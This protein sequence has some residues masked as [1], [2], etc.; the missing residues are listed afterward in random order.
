MNDTNK[1]RIYLIYNEHQNFSEFIK[2]S[3]LYKRVF[4]HLDTKFGLI[5]PIETKNKKDK[6][7]MFSKYDSEC[8]IILFIKNDE[9]L[10]SH[11]NINLFSEW[12]LSCF[13]KIL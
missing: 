8:P 4:D 5:N 6:K 1:I 9:V 12:V 11:K 10:N 13:S 3:S 2:F 7:K